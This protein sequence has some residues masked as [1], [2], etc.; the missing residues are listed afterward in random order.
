MRRNPTLV[1]ISFLIAASLLLTGCPL[2]D[3]YYVAQ[4]DLGGAGS[5]GELE[6]GGGPDVSLSGHG[7]VPGEGGRSSAGGSSGGLGASGTVGASGAAA[8]IEP[9]ADGCMSAANQGHEYAFCF[10]SKIQADARATCGDRGMTLAV[11]E[12]QAENAWI[13][14]TFS[15]L[16]PGLGA[17]GFIGANDVSNEGEWRWASGTTFWR[18][19]SAVSGSYANWAVGQPNEGPMGA[20]EDCLTIGVSDGMWGDMSCDTELPYVCEPR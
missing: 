5:S 9:D 3:G 18:A 15:G 2:T 4:A 10:S 8:I 12:D 11:I 17:R 7:G 20:M 1:P 6:V 16:Y 13:A 14:K 19:G